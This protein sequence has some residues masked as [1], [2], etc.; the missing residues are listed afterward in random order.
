MEG[1]C[2]MDNSKDGYILADLKPRKKPD[3][4]TAFPVEVLPRPVSTYIIEGAKAMGCDPVFIA[5]PMLSAAA[6]AIGNSRRIKLK[7][8]W[9][10]PS[11]IW[12]GIIGDSGSMKSPA[13]DLA[14]RPLRRM[15]SEA[16]RVHDKELEEYQEELAEYEL[17]VKRRKKNDLMPDKPVE[18]VAKR[19]YCGDITIEAL[20]G[21]LK[22]APRGLLLARDEL[23]GWLKGFN[24][25]KKKGGDEAQW[26]E[27]HRAGTLLVDRKSGVPKTIHIPNASVSVTGGIQ[28]GILAAAL[29]REF[30]ENGLAARLLLAMPP[31]RAKR[32]TDAD[33]DE[34]LQ[35]QIDAVFEGL[36]GLKMTDDEFGG[37]EP[38]DVPLTLLGQDAWI[39]FYDEHAAEQAEIAGG[40]LSAAWSKLE[41]YAARLALVVHCL[42]IATGDESLR[43]DDYIDEDSIAAAVTI[44]RWF[45]QETRRV[46]GML[47]ESD[48]QREQTRLFELIQSKGGRITVRELMQ[49]GRQYRGSAE[50]AESALKELADIGWGRWQ[51]VPGEPAG[52]R[53]S[54]KFVLT[55]DRGGNKTPCEGPE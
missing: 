12:T 4:F 26:L 49:A 23:S 53:P 8:S 39:K 18:P 34:E 19:Y 1:G 20:A 15:Q 10:E 33:I 32:W 35:L 46:Y 3:E 25:Y 30:F 43:T 38:V 41:G 5:L 51:T 37:L 48:D 2:V 9:K 14:M 6:A 55:D 44:T 36:L 40:D 24:A 50:L 45:G 27:L 52:G 7:E 22:D 54:R 42:R 31:K 47:A 28:P 29:G 21:L 17:A 11:I 13:I 16:F